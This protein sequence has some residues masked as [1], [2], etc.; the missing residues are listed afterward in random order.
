ME[1][2]LL[3]ERH[4]NRDFFIA[5]IFD[6]S[7]IFKSDSA[8][9][10]HPVFSLATKPDMRV[11]HYEHRGQWI[12]IHPSGYGL[13]T[14]L[15]KDVL[16]YAGSLLMERINQGEIPS[17][18]IAFNAHDL[19]VN[20]NRQTSGRGYELLHAA[21]LRLRGTTIETNVLTNNLEQERGFGIINEFNI[22][23]KTRPKGRMLQVE[24]ELSNWF[25]NALLG[26]EVL[27]ISRDY[28]RLRRPM[29]RRLYE[30]ARKHC[31][32]QEKWMIGLE[33]LK[34]KL[35]TKAAKKKV[36]YNLREIEKTNHL[37]HYALETTENGVTFFNRKKYA[38][39]HTEFPVLQPSTYEKAK[40]AAPGFDVYALEQEWN[41][42]WAG[43]GKPKLK[44]A[45]GAFISFCRR[46]AHQEGFGNPPLIGMELSK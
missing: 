1:N 45:D 13:A 25:Y 7:A 5:D 32:K 29:E 44:T 35:G 31:G 3:P 14:I 23:R 12:T 24:I 39:L 2:L 41:L 15:D 38:A 22:I 43:S 4:P 33:T 34:T 21:L 37:P 18:R 28:F 6:S 16:L 30:L 46:R 19:L 26:K 11:L 9:L 10:E 8:S 20:T 27:S 17:P 40:N 42:F 36:A